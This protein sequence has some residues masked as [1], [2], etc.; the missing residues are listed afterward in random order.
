MCASV[1][2]PCET[3]STFGLAWGFVRLWGAFWDLL[4]LSGMQSRT[5]CI[6]MSQHLHT[7]VVSRGLK[8]SDSSQA[9]ASWCLLLVACCYTLA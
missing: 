3:R 4:V 7:A 5:W 6:R 2:G 1:L 9:L 8:T